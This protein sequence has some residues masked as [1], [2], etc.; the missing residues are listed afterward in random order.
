MRNTISMD[1]NTIIVIRVIR[2]KNLHNYTESKLL[3]YFK[4]RILTWYNRK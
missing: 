1:K 4:G 3:A 2:V